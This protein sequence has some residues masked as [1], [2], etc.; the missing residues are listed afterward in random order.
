[1]E[2]VKSTVLFLG[3]L[4]LIANLANGQAQSSKKEE[5]WEKLD[6][7]CGQLVYFEH[8]EKHGK[9]MEETSKPLKNAVLTLYARESDSCCE[10]VS[11][12]GETKTGRDGRFILDAKPAAYWLVTVVGGREY[13]L[14]LRVQPNGSKS[15]ICSDQVFEVYDSG[16]FRIGRIITVD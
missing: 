6:R 10:N 16:D 1:V 2:R 4:A 11:K 3:G 7:M 12:A 9:A 15:A 5:E 8:H 14:P 13:K